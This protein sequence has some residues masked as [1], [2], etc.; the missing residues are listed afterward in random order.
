MNRL[1]LHC[2]LDCFFA[3]VEIRDNPKLKGKPVIIGA[4]PK[5]GKGR[6][7]VS[8]CS[9]EARK[10]GLRSGMP[11]SKAFKL[12]PHGTYLKPSFKKYSDDSKKVMDI[13][14][15]QSPIFQQAGIDEAYLDISD[16]FL[17]NT[18][19]NF[20][21]EKIR[22]EI[23]KKVGIT[24]SIGCAPTKS[25]AKIASGMAKPNGI[26]IITPENFKNC[27]KD[28]E[29]TRIP[30]IGNKSKV[31]YYKN[32]I[33]KIG[34]II[35]TPCSRMIELFGKHGKWVWKVVNGLDNR[36]VKEFGR[37][38]KSISKERTFHID[39]NNFSLVLS[40]I[41]E[42]NESIHKLIK[43]HNVSY[44]TITLKIRFEDFETFT[45]SRMLPF[46]IQEKKKVIDVILKL[47]NEFSN[48]KKKIRLVGI[49]LSRLEYHLKVK[50]TNLLDFLKG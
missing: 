46:H 38:R 14:K 11:I 36:K 9:Y 44:K 26:A 29:I 8:T 4:D 43:M 24:I 41:E 39:T 15:K 10:F 50:Q 48:I 6:G 17:D 33:R 35:N 40:K 47:Y 3:A 19:V 25:L 37:I 42:L 32:G 23:Y 28:M 2:D 34:D 45:R 12:C 22:K 13:L 49:K 31:N 1:I 5:G 30:G 18:D 20:I 21:A 27:L 16:I 7:V